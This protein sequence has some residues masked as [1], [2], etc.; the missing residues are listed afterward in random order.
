MLNHVLFRGAPLV[1]LLFVLV[2]AFPQDLSPLLVATQHDSHTTANAPQP[3]R[4]LH[5]FIM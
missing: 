2:P 4:V 5:A 3:E 1:K